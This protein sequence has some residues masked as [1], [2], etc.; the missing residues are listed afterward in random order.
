MVR[1]LHKFRGDSVEFRAWAA[2]IARHRALDHVRYTRRRPA[3]P[4]PPE[5]FPDARTVPDAADL[6]TEKLS[7]IEPSR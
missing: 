4:T 1:D 3:Y 5:K 6:A 2:T 7:T